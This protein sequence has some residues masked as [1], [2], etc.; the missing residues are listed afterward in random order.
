MNDKLLLKVSDM[1]TE[2]AI[3]RQDIHAHPET[4]ME[5]ERTSTFVAS[6][7][8]E[9]GLTVTEDIGRFGVVDTLTSLQPGPQMAASDRWYVTFK[10]TG[11]H[12]GIGPHIAAD[13]TML[14]ASSL[15]ESVR[16]LIELLNHEEQTKRA[17]KVAETVIGLANVNKNKDPQMGGEDFAFMLLKRPGAFIFMGINDEA[18]SVKLHSPDYN[19]NDDAIPF[20]VA[21]WISLVQQEL[22]N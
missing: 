17:I 19:F 10:G 21:Y 1:Q 16:N 20:G 22:N 12:G 4:S 7:L 3:I 2:L 6:K 11:G 14:Q 8:R 15:N 13:V 5:E 9:C 18:V